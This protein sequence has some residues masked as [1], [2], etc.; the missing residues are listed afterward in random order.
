MSVCVCAGG[1]GPSVCLF[2]YPCG[3]FLCRV[4][5][6][7]EAEVDGEGTASVPP[8]TQSHSS[9]DQQAITEEEEEGTIPEE[10][11][12]GDSTRMRE[13]EDRSA[14]SGVGGGE[15]PFK[16][17][18]GTGAT[19]T[20]ASKVGGCV[21]NWK[22]QALHTVWSSLNTAVSCLIMTWKQ[23]SLTLLLLCI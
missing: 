23:K 1:A 22:L 8:A 20:V 7:R 5:R 9:M 10:M 2:L 15:H 13:E 18:S 12:V 3:C 6:G 17:P 14:M 11:E 16:P 4:S 21:W 19:A